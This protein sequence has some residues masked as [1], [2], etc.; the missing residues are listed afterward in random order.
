MNRKNYFIASICILLSI[1]ACK[2]QGAP[3]PT[4]QGARPDPIS[5]VHVQNLPGGA[6][7]QYTLPA[8]EDLLYVK[9]IYEF[10]AGTLKEVKASM[11]VDSLRI[12]GLGNEDQLEVKLYA[13]SRSEVVSEPVS[14][15][16]KPL[17][18]PVISIAT[19][20]NL[21]ESFGGITLTY[22]NTSMLN[23]VINFVK[24]VNN[25]WVEIDALYTNKREGLYTV[26]NQESVRTE[27]GA[28]VKDRWNNKSDT[29]KVTLTPLF[30]K[31]IPKPTPI[32]YLPGDYNKHFTNFN[33]T[34]M[35]DGNYTNYMGTL[36]AT[37]SDLPQS[38]TLDF[39]VPTAFSRFKYWMIPGGA[40]REYNYAH[41]E[42]WEIWAT[43]DLGDD[44]SKWTKIMDCKA[45]KLSGAP[46]G[47]MTAE[48]QAASRAG[49]DFSFPANVPKYR[50]IRWKTNKVFGGLP[51]VQIAELMFWGNQ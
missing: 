38:F 35:F 48:D 14:V 43:N 9:A 1:T 33:Y 17:T 24:K 20:F 27:F 46:L 8:S 34:Y 2:K 44:W 18:P 31:Q 19:S 12:E 4:A 32:T 39:G 40:T 23:L 6:K 26:R 30:E 3:A 25:E 21:K 45:V 11:Y 50:Y 36:A 47:I 7:L 5:N 41:P 51:A 22:T 28:F 15:K 13:V 29:L 10:P 37:G 49:L 16:I 42:E